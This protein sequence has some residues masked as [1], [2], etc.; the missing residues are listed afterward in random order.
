MQIIG[1][2]KHTAIKLQIYSKGKY[3]NTETLI[4][5]IDIWIKF[6]A[7]DAFDLHEIALDAK[8]EAAG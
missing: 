8:C 2:N 3:P 5:A 1:R 6:I 7:P 4:T